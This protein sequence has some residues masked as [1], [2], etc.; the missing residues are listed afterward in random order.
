MFRN[1]PMISRVVYG[2]GC[3]DQLDEILAERRLPGRDSMVFVVDDVFDG[4]RSW[5]TGSR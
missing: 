1:F 5:R 4:P 3:F 2:R